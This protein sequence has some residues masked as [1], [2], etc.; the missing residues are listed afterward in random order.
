MNLGSRST[1]VEPLQELAFGFS[2]L[3]F[4]VLVHA[5][6]ATEEGVAALRIAVDHEPAVP[7][8]LP[9]QDR[10][11]PIEIDQVHVPSQSLGDFGLSLKN[12]VGLK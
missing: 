6:R 11:N 5:D 7:Q 12:L 2:A 10:G 9:G 3:D 8:N 4:H 1:T